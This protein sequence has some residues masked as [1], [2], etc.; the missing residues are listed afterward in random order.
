MRPLG[1]IGVVLGAVAAGW[2][3]AAALALRVR[4]A[5]GGLGLEQ[6]RVARIVALAGVSVGAGLGARAALPAT[7]TEGLLGSLAVLAA[8][9]LAFLVAARLLNLFSLRSLTRRA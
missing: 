9:G 4:S 8:F 6:V 3:E 1:V 2:V 5:I 7:M